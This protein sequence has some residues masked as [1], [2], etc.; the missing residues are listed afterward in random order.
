MSKRN[1]AFYLIWL[2]LLLSSCGS[3]TAR[4]IGEVGLREGLFVLLISMLI[5]PLLSRI[6]INKRIN[7][8]KKIWLQYLALFLVDLMFFLYYFSKVYTKE[9]ILETFRSFASAGILLLIVLSLLAVPYL[10]LFTLIF[11]AV[12]PKKYIEY[13]PTIIMG[14]YLISFIVMVTTN[15]D[16]E[17]PLVFMLNPVLATLLL[18][19]LSILLFIGLIFYIKMKKI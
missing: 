5:I 3:L 4:Q 18:W 1:L 8:N 13:L 17:N 7:F 11:I 2:S 9:Y 10:L 12:I 6:S 14:I 15:I 16:I 19:W